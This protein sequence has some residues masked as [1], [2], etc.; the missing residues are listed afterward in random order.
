MEAQRSDSEVTRFRSEPSEQA[1]FG[2]EGTIRFPGG[3]GA[4]P[5]FKIITN[6]TKIPEYLF[7]G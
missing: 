4:C 3:S 7:S 6:T 2:R 1:L 5:P